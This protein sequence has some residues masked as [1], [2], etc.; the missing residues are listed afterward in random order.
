ME[1]TP[2]LSLYDPTGLCKLQIAFSVPEV[3]NNLTSFLLCRAVFR[4]SNPKGGEADGKEG[5]WGSEGLSPSSPPSD[6]GSIMCILISYTLCNV[7]LCIARNYQGYHQYFV[8]SILTLTTY[9]PRV[10][11]LH[12]TYPLFT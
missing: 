2:L 5:G 9:P 4:F 1:K 12:N 8:P 11:I 3:L 10:D 6:D 7:L